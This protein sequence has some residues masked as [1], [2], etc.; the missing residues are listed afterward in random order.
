[1]AAFSL[2]WV[3]QQ[4]LIGAP[5]AVLAS[6]NTGAYFLHEFTFFFLLCYR[7]FGIQFH[8]ETS[9]FSIY[10]AKLDPEILKP[11]RWG[12]RTSIWTR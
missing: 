3:L 8:V 10:F 1:M 11:V 9:L 2:P 12:F 6:L 7:P 5:L 4:A